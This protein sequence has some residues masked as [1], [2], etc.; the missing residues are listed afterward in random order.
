M[1]A[2]GES[3]IPGSI[4]VSVIPSP[5]GR[6]TVDAV[7]ENLTSHEAEDDDSTWSRRSLVTLPD[8]GRAARREGVIDV[9]LPDGRQVVRTVVMQTFVPLT[10]GR[11]LLVAAASPALDLVDPLLELFDAV[12]ATLTLVGS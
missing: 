6:A 3:I 10:D 2:V 12:T 8:V 5:H 1:I 11:L 9:P 4:T 7:A